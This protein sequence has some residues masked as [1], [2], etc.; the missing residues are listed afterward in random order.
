MKGLK[1]FEMI[2]TEEERI[3]YKEK[4]MKTIRERDGNSILNEELVQIFN[5]I[6]FEYFIKDLKGEKESIIEKIKQYETEITE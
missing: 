4:L 6:F 3:F 5:T 1:K 2:L